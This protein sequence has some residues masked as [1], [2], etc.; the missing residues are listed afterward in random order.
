[1][2]GMVQFSLI[3]MFKA[4]LKIKLRSLNKLNMSPFY[5]LLSFCW[6]CNFQGKKNFKWQTYNMLEYIKENTLKVSC[7]SCSGLKL[8]KNVLQQKFSARLRH[9]TKIIKVTLFLSIITFEFYLNIQKR[10]SHQLKLW[11]TY[12]ICECIP[13]IVKANGNTQ[14]I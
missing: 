12:N 6:K 5:K 10:K 1:M 8:C 14:K 2:L 4:H 7:I 13:H 3:L 11:H 9:D